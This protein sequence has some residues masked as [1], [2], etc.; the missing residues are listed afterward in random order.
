MLIEEK[1]P[2]DP[3]RAPVFI[4]AWLRRLRPLGLNDDQVFGLKLCLQEALIN[5]I[6]HGNKCN[7]HL[8]VWVKIAADPRCLAVEITDQGQGFDP[9]AVPDP[10]APENIG[11][12]HG[13]GI[14]L[15]RQ[16]MGAVDFS[17]GGRTIKMVMPLTGDRSGGH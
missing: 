13:R 5:A 1:L 10:T 17:N 15:I 14:Y 8:A 4:E 11:K 2:S 12:N 3:D 7:K 16:T 9:G 6:K